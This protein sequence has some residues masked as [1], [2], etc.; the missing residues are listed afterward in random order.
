MMNF[1]TCFDLDNKLTYLY[2]FLCE[3]LK[4]ADFTDMSFAT[5]LIFCYVCNE[6]DNLKDLE[7]VSEKLISFRL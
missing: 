2:N 7:E 4:G 6:F 1:I 5:K 3:E